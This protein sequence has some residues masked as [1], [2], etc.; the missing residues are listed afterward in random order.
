M[1]I[2][3]F[4]SVVDKPEN[5][6]D[7]TFFKEKNGKVYAVCPIAKAAVKRGYR[8]SM[9]I[10]SH[11]SL[12]ESKFGL[13]Y[14]ARI[15]FTRAWDARISALRLDIEALSDRSKKRRIE[16]SNDGLTVHEKRMAFKQALKAAVSAEEEHA[17]KTRKEASDGKSCS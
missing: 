1:R 13:C 2:E 14:E 4:L 12:I 7:R 9:D 10:W 3:E 16:S 17:H 15:A 11:G 5:C 6:K 8:P